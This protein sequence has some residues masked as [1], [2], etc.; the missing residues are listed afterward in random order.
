MKLSGRGAR[1]EH[2]L[3]EPAGRRN[4]TAEE[5]GRLVVVSCRSAMTVTDVARQ[6]GAD[7]HLLR[8]G[9][10]VARRV[11]H[12]DHPLAH[13]PRRVE[14]H[15]LALIDRQVSRDLARAAVLPLG[16]PCVR[17]GLARRLPHGRASARRVIAGQV[18]LRGR[19][20]GASIRSPD[21]AADPGTPRAAPLFVWRD[22]PGDAQAV[23]AAST[24]ARRGS[25]ATAP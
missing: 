21:R 14:C 3:A 10:K 22:R 23:S 9:D 11:G 15:A 8:T 17:E 24:V 2:V 12:A 19:S 5:K 18:A 6:A 25:G 20:K 4:H 16:E 1:R 13:L 7:P